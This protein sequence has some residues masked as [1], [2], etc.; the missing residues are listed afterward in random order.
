[1]LDWAL[2]KTSE[3]PARILL[4]EDSPINQ[5]LFSEILQDMG[6]NVTLADTGIRALHMLERESFDLVLMDVEMPELDGLSATRLLR[7]RGVT[8]PVIG[9]TGH[10]SAADAARCL[11]AGMTDHLVKPV[12]FDELYSM[13][14]RYKVA[15]KV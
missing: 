6:H 14:E 12:D 3:Q 13:V 11:A 4:A 7:E 8:L 1:M 10:A 2:R 9:M 15:E 5:V